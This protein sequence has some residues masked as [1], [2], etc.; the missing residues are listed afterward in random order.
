VIAPPPPRPLLEDK[1][2]PQKP[3]LDA[4]KLIKVTKEI[5]LL[6][7]KGHEVLTGVKTNKFGDVT[8]AKYASVNPRTIMNGVRALPEQIKVVPPKKRKAPL[9]VHDE[10]RPWM[11]FALLG[12][13]LKI[14]PMLYIP[15]NRGS[16]K[17]T[18]IARARNKN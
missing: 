17:N 16:T 18:F 4:Q 10:K 9:V 2:R 3:Q 7:P 12:K 14:S 8:C 1:P 13:R 11:T 5:N 6:P 15:W